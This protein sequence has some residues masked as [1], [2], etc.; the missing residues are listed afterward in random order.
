MTRKLP[1]LPYVFREKELNKINSCL[2][3]EPNS[4]DLLLA[5][6]DLLTGLGRI[7]EAK[8]TYMEAVTMA[9]TH[10]E[11]LNNFGKLLFYTGF[12]SAARTIYK[13][14]IEHHPDSPIGYVNMATI[15]YKDRELEKAREYYEKT[16]KLNPKQIEAHRGLSYIF[17]EF[18][19]EETS[20]LHRRL[21]FENHSVIFQPFR[22]KGEPITVLQLI[23]AAGGNIP[24]EQFLDESI[25]LTAVVATEYFD[26]N[27][28]LPIHKLVINAVA[29]A[30]LNKEA[31]DAVE[32][33]LAKTSAPVINYP[34]AVKKTTRAGTS[35]RLA[36]IPGVI[37]PNTINLV[38]EVLESDTNLQTLSDHGFKFPL[39]LR[40]PG[41]HTG[42][43]FTL[44]ANEDELAMTLPTLPGNELMVIEYLDARSADG[45]IRKY[46]VMMIDGNLYP[47]HLAISHE[48]KIHYFSA[49]MAD[50]PEHRA[51]DKA[52]LE[53]MPEVLGTKAMEAL[54]NIQNT[55][56]LDYAGIDFSLNAKGEILLFE[57]NA[58]MNVIPPDS[59]ERWN[60][61]RIHVAKIFSAVKE[62]LLKKVDYKVPT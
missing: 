47:L 38:R 55:L 12:T 2:A 56:G 57:A 40:S 31:L 53:N 27:L 51:E 49:E 29:D 52:F 8:S 60:Y 9:P 32:K 10:F 36:G 46:R 16:L 61:R 42:Q 6:A 18:G 11:A 34:A 48:W 23:S 20:K 26:L 54:K 37:A 15:S 1:W 50:N 22:G 58:A 30:D 4:I 45:K 59:D 13:Q 24:I 35:S 25:F 19:D 33:I 5:K 44:V 62:M 28:P 21:A 7:E 14:M 17:R 43:Y 39:L 3:L 41:F